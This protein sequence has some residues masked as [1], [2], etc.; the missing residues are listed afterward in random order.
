MMTLAFWCYMCFEAYHTAKKRQLGFPVEEWSSLLGP[1]PRTGA[2]PIG[3]IILIGIGVAGGLYGPRI[4]SEASARNGWLGRAARKFQRLR[5]FALFRSPGDRA[6]VRGIDGTPP[7]RHGSG[8]P[9][10]N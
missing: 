1:A 8:A 4:I 7:R 3:P 2:L 5:S 9:A 10:G 6:V